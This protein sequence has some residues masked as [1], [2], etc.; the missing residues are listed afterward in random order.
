MTPLLSLQ[1]AHRSCDAHAVS[2]CRRIMHGMQRIGRR[3]FEP[4]QQMAQVGVG[5]SILRWILTYR[6][7]TR[8]PRRGHQ[9][10]QTHLRTCS[11]GPKLVR[12][13]DGSA[14][15][16]ARH[17]MAS[18]GRTASTV[19]SRLGSEEDSIGAGKRASQQQVAGELGTGQLV[20]SEPGEELSPASSLGQQH[21]LEPDISLDCNSAKARHQPAGKASDSTVHHRR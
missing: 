3:P 14:K 11:G 5:K 16:E 10:R 19:S 1:N 6:A 20:L 18:G 21:G 12:G 13:S 15:R 7:S 4:L 8:S 2:D 9:H 17:K